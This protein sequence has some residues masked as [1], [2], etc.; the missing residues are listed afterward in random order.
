[1]SYTYNIALN[2]PAGLE[3][4][5][6]QRDILNEPAITAVLQGLISDT[7]DLT[8]TF[9]SSLSA[10]EL[11]ALNSVISNYIFITQPLLDPTGATINFCM[12]N[13]IYRADSTAFQTI[14]QLTWLDSR[15]RRFTESSFIADFIIYDRNLE[16]ILYDV[17][18]AVTLG[19]AIVVSSG[20]NSY[21][22]SNPTSDT[23]IELRVRKTSSGGQAPEITSSTLEYIA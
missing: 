9:N 5:Q 3:L 18:N 13:L 6:L 11:T 1:M 4:G 21:S 14:T 2:F 23:T 15:Y 8:I 19:T 12:T 20:K 7:I 22:I 16:W 10:P 17:T